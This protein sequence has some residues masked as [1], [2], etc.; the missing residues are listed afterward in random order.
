MN[1]EEKKTEKQ[2]PVQN[3]EEWT[4]S[5]TKADNGYVLKGKSDFGAPMTLVIEEDDKDELKASEALLWEIMEYFSFGGSKH[6][7]ERIRIT[8]EKH[9]EYSRKISE[10]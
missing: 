2:I 1:E 7:R 8:R 3:Y 9:K 5:I 4:L 10:K 6:D